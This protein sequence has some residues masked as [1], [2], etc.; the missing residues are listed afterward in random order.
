MNLTSLTNPTRLSAFDHRLT[1][2]EEQNINQ[3]MLHQFNVQILNWGWVITRLPTEAKLSQLHQPNFDISDEVLKDC[4]LDELKLSHN[5][6]PSLDQMLSLIGFSC[7]QVESL[8]GLQSWTHLQVL[9]LE[10]IRSEN[11]SIL[12]KLPNL[13]VLTINS[14]KVDIDVKSISQIQ[15]LN[16]LNIKKSNL[17]N[18]NYF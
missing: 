12:A 18:L 8:A 3:E 2:K 13:K 9:W 1:V 15:S 6:T 11:L 5:Q 7:S 16:Y 14:K 4:I 17:I 10:D